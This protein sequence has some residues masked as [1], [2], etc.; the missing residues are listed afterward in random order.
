MNENPWETLSS[1]LKY[2]NKW[3]S[4]TEHLVKH[5]KAGKGIYGVVHFK[6]IAI[7]ILPV[8]EEGNTWLVGQYRYPLKTYSWEIPEGGGPLDV[9]PLVSAKRELKE[10][11]GMEAKDWSVFLETDLSNS[12]TDEKSI[13]YLARG[14]SFGE[15]HPEDDERLTVKKISLK[16]ALN[17][18][19]K[20]E[21]RDAITVAA[22][23]KWGL[24]TDYSNSQR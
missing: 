10:E 9:D 4:L 22:L 13:I 19:L 21:I 17:Q 23:L 15:A 2:D 3:I 14:L 7:G 8:D 11:T 6:N 12:A 16:E 1:E 24:S 5:E 20:G 18:V